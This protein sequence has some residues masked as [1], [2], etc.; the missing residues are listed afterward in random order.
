MSRFMASL[1]PEQRSQ[2]QGLAEDLMGD[3][4][5][6]FE[7]SRLNANL[8]GMMPGMGWDEGVG[9]EGDRLARDG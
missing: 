2:L 6:S 8:R 1:S 9:F 3:M 4:D 5:L 7:V